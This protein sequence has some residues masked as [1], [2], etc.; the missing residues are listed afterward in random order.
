MRQNEC[1]R[2]ANRTVAPQ[3][4]AAFIIFMHMLKR[5]ERTRGLK[6]KNSKDIEPILM[7]DPVLNHP[8]RNAVT[9][10]IWQTSL[11]P[12]TIEKK[13]LIYFFF[14]TDLVNYW[15][16]SSRFTCKFLSELCCSSTDISAR[17]RSPF[18]SISS[19]PREWWNALHITR[20]ISNW[21]LLWKPPDP[22]FTMVQKYPISRAPALA[23]SQNSSL[24]AELRITSRRMSSTGNKMSTT[25]TATSMIQIRSSTQHIWKCL[26]K[27]HMQHCS[28]THCTG[29]LKSTFNTREAAVTPV[30]SIHLL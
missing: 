7:H 8:R 27:K 12:R 24:A 3:I 10:I 11:R 20:T 30:T 23:T 22:L 13:H 19:W 15:V 14:T 2:P 5:R 28:I 9:N 26:Q 25:Y 29:L 16:K 4:Y 21:F 17:R 18:S 6:L 1:K